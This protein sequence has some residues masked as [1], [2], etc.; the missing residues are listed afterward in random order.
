[1]P[2]KK[3]NERLKKDLLDFVE[4]I[5]IDVSQLESYHYDS[6]PYC[7]DDELIG[8]S[9]C[10]VWSESEEWQEQISAA[11]K[12]IKENGACE[13][14]KM[15]ADDWDNE[16]NLDDTTLTNECLTYLETLES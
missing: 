8:T 6:N 16:D 2:Y 3:L 4:K 7:V 13:Y 14:L 1:M 5:E 9:G 15:S 10:G 12:K 11:K